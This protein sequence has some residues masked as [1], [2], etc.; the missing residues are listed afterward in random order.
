M[1]G[2][3]CRGGDEGRREWG[4]GSRGRAGGGGGDGSGERVRP[5]G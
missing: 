1:R 4:V 5:L 2:N 3:E